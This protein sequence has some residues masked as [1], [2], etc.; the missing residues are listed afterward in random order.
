MKSYRRPHSYQKKRSIF[1]ARFFWPCV[2]VFILFC[3]ISYFL[4]FAQYFQ[5]DRVVVSN[6]KRVNKEDL[7]FLVE[8]HLEKKVMFLS[9]KSIF[10]INK[11][12]LKRDAFSIFPQIADIEVTRSLPRTLNVI[13][14]E[15]L[16]RATFCFE[17]D[18][19]LLDIEGV[20]FEPVVSGATDLVEIHDELKSGRLGE[21][22]IEKELLEKILRVK[23]VL[24]ENIKIKANKVFVFPQYFSIET[25][26]GW[27][28]HFN[29][30]EDLD[31]QIT[32]LNAVLEE[33]IPKEDRGY[34][35]YIDLRFGNFAPYKYK[36]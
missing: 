25:A 21:K 31:W 35:E 18:C 28:I 5:I 30:A 24:L 9:T 23:D 33:K 2:L 15:R 26:D 3:V 22:V 32:K 36:D 10:L 1:R 12:E 13:I 4:F 27:L 11:G 19:F 16:E 20:V 6:A 8:S 7:Q 17:D 14:I 29:P 34:L